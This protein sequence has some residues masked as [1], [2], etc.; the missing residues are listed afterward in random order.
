VENHESEKV[1]AGV[2]EGSSLVGAAL[3]S[4]SSLPLNFGL[5]AKIMRNFKYMKLP[6]SQELYETFVS[7]KVASGFM[8]A[9]KDWSSKYTSKTIPVVFSRYE[10]QSAFLINF[11]KP[12]IMAIIEIA[13]FGAFKLIEVSI[14]DKKS[15]VYTISRQVNVAASNF[16]LT[17]FYSNLDDVIFY[18][19]LEMRSTEFE[20]GF[21]VGSSI[22]AI[23]LLLV[24]VIFVVLHSKLI[25]RYQNL[26]GKGS[27]TQLKGFETK[28]ENINLIFKDFKDSSSLV[29]SFLMIN[30][31]RSVVTSL[32]FAT[33]F[34]YPM[35]QISFLFVLNIL[36]IVYLLTKKSF[37]EFTNTCGQFFCELVLF[38]ANICV[39]LLAL[40]DHADS[41]PISFIKGLSK[42]II[43]LNWILLFGCAILLLVNLLKTLYQSYLER[44]KPQQPPLSADKIFASAKFNRPDSGLE[45]LDQSLIT[46]GGLINESQSD[47][48]QNN[49]LKTASEDYEKLERTPKMG[50]QQGDSNNSSIQKRQ[51]KQNP[52]R[53]FEK[54]N[55]NVILQS[56]PTEDLKE[57]ISQPNIF[58][59]PRSRL[60]RNRE[61]TKARIAQLSG[62]EENPSPENR[63]RD[64]SFHSG[65]DLNHEEMGNQELSVT[66]F[67]I[68]TNSPPQRGNDL[69]RRKTYDN[70]GK[71][72]AGRMRK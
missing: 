23:A 43:I 66:S 52:N 31:V 63:F 44:R 17:Q 14:N 20:T 61:I 37:K 28:C 2:F 58:S 62:I 13:V 53:G 15:V 56:N 46:N 4:G 30:V 51:R 48:Y 65:M 72:T 33:L 24:G 12:F 3:G 5:V 67:D 21:R 11:W 57:T 54:S 36:M 32:I 18:F 42:C 50:H 60:V 29:Q 64:P 59:L 40:F 41:Y 19:I 25:G 71:V 49:A 26:K 7:W 10:L 55:S 39:F 69:R 6:V 45:Q 47:S 22:L 38:I 70:N 16:A 27:S 8:S 1:A 9:P 35:I 68:E 34:E